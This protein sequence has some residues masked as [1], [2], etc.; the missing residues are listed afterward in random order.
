MAE[1]PKSARTAFKPISKMASRSILRDRNPPNPPDEE[2]STRGLHMVTPAKNKLQSF[3]GKVDRAG[4]STPPPPVP[5]VPAQHRIS[6][7]SSSSGGGAPVTPFK[8]PRAYDHGTIL[9]SMTTA[10]VP[11]PLPT[12]KIRA[13]MTPEARTR[14]MPTPKPLPPSKLRSQ[15]TSVTGATSGGGGGGGG[16]VRL[17]QPR[18]STS[19]PFQS[20][21][22][23]FARES[24]ELP[25]QTRG[26][27]VATETF[28]DDWDTTLGGSE[29]VIPETGWQEIGRDSS[30]ETVLVTVRYVS[31]RLSAAPKASR[32]LAA[33]TNGNLCNS[34]ARR[35]GF[36]RS[37][38]LIRT[39]ETPGPHR[40]MRGI[41]SHGRSDCR[42]ELARN[43][44]LVSPCLLVR[45]SEA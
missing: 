16:T 24:Y 39:M 32:S 3:F 14:L 38:R 10:D 42:M 13:G 43:G 20:G 1:S 29:T 17:V 35:V 31:T 7:A 6:T 19:R 11:P 28:A 26:L 18:K 23:H 30:N 22:D 25:L 27:A 4:S 9:Q 8:T 45:V 34:P 5:V 15:T 40:W 37:P 44:V 36:D 2:H 33:L 12:P 41:S 21:D